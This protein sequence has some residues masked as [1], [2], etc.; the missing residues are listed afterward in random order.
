MTPLAYRQ[1]LFFAKNESL[2]MLVLRD[3]ILSVGISNKEIRSLVDRRFEMLS[4]DAPYDPELHGFFVVL[5]EGDNLSELD[6]CLGFSIFTNR[7][8]QT[9]FGN[10]DFTP[11]FELLEEHC[12]CYEMVFVLS[13]DGYGVEVFVPKAEWVDS[14]LLAICHQYAKPA[15]E[16]ID[17]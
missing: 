6:R 5:E 11:S 12:C 7:L 3:P 1:G 4:T 10:I 8:N 17:L 15:Q 14:R 2:I 13:D 16:S 9:N